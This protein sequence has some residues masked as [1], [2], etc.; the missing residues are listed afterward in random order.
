[1]SH[2]ILGTAQEGR[3][4]DYP[5]CE[6]LLAR[7]REAAAGAGARESTAGTSVEG[8]PIVRFDLGQE[9]APCVL[10]TA[11]MHGVEVIGALALLDVLWRW[12]DP[13]D[14]EARRVRERAHIVVLPIVNPDACDANMSRLG[15]GE[16][17]FQRCNANGVDLNRNFP[18]LT[19]RRLLHPFSGSRF[20]MSPHYM[21]PHALS[22]PESR[23]VRAVA[24]QLRPELSLAF[25]SFGNLLL[26]PWAYTDRANPRAA[27]YL[28]LAHAMT[29]TLATP[30]DVRQARQ[31]YSVLGDMDDWLDAEL[32]T[33]AFTVEVSR[34]AFGLSELGHLS[35]PF[36]WMNPR[37]A[38]ATVRNLTPGVFAL[39]SAS[40]GLTLPRG[41]AEP[42]RASVRPPLAAK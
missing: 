2:D 9:G 32:G 37:K 3:F 6:G 42:L 41:R 40:L 29:S 1:M 18:R 10:L 8:R 28:D 17:A 34:P 26:Y 14:S 16:R 36:A 4:R 22:E 5:S 30:Y 20:R 31:L 21:G 19:T 27:R 35:N 11:L 24:T 33:L 12:A 38:D 13:T 25:H 7:F 15:R 23:A 39:L